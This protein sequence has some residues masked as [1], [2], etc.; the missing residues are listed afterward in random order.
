MKIMLLM[1]LLVV[2]CGHTYSQDQA[3][4]PKVFNQTNGLA[5]DGYDP[6]SYFQKNP[7]RGS[8]DLIYKHQGLTFYFQSESNRQTFIN[9]TDA[10]LPQYGG[11]CAYAMA[12]S[13]KLVSV[14][15]ETY[16]LINGK[17]YLFYN[18]YLNN[19]LKKWNKNENEYLIQSRNNWIE[20]LKKSNY[21]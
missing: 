11:W 3:R 5:L 1:I 14:D 12:Q 17:L 20:I 4:L 21:E 8:P 13:G 18:A 10:Y 9:S 15:P 7:Q 2:S 6:V 16:K 19:T